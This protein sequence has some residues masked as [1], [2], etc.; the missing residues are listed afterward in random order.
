MKKIFKIQE[1]KPRIF[2][3]QFDNN[4]DMCMYFLRYQEYYESASPQF[5]GKQFE[6]LDFMKWYAL[7]YGG[8]IFTYTKDWGG[9]NFPAYIIPYVWELGILDK[10]IYDYEMMDAW[11][12]CAD[13]GHGDFYIIG[14]TTNNGITIN[15]E[16]AHGL[17][18]L[19]PEYKLEM[20]KLVKAL[21]PTFRAKI[22]TTLQKVGY[23]PKVYVDE[24]QAYMATGISK[25]FSGLD[26]C[27][28]ICKPFKSFFRKF[29][30]SIK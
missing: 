9:F 17:F 19:Y 15:H 16:V 24:T 30:M 7:K 28:V 27:G 18:Y 29:S 2:L 22:N 14:A 4:Y 12:Q 25:H 5:R 20:T 6:I 1:I 21:P 13:K 11:K 3:F 23:T 10:N 8:G 26:E